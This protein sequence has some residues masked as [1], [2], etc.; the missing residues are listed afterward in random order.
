M[1]VHVG[2][3]SAVR[4]LPRE[5]SL[6]RTVPDVVPVG[7]YLPAR[8]AARIADTLVDGLEPGAL[9]RAFIVAIDLQ[10][11]AALRILVDDAGQLALDALALRLVLQHLTDG[12]LVF[13]EVARDVAVDGRAGIAGDQRMILAAGN[14]VGR[15]GRKR[16]DSQGGQ[17]ESNVPHR[18][19]PPLC[20]SR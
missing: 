17:N 2:D 6:V 7:S 9:E 8:Q 15:E 19:R 12:Q 10:G 13:I 5:L 11:R 3:R 4:Q 16:Y 20:L 1:K 14:V 18:H